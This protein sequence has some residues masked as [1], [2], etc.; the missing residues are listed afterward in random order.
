MS[1]HGSFVQRNTNGVVAAFLEFAPPRLVNQDLPHY[2]RGDA[3]KVGPAFPLNL[4]L[5][6]QS[7]VSLV[8]QRG[9]LQHM[10]SFFAPHVL[11]G[12][13]PQFLIYQRHQLICRRL[14]TAGPIL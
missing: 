3:N 11:M 2:G 12:Q 14:I 5:I 1:Y 10:A 7:H 6:N 8:N 9:G 4:A 13:T